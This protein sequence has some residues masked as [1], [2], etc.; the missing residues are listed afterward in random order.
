M[1]M[2]LAGTYN[3]ELYEN[4]TNLIKEVGFDFVDAAYHS[5]I[6]A[7][8]Y[9]S[10]NPE[11]MV[12]E[13]QKFINTAITNKQPFFLYFA[14]TL[15]HDPDIETALFNHS[16]AWTPKGELFGNDIPSPANT[17]MKDRKSIWAK[18]SNG[19]YKTASRIAT[20]AADIWIDDALGA[21]TNYLENQG[22]LDDTMIIVMNDHGMGAKGLLYEQGLRIIQSIRYPQLFGKPGHILPNDFIT[23]GTDLA[24]VIYDIVNI[25][26]KTQYPEYIMDG[27]S[28]INDVVNDINNPN[29]DY[30]INGP[31]SCC[32][33]R[34]GDVYNSHAVITRDYKYIFRASNVIESDGSFSSYYQNVTDIEQLYDLR[35]D[36]CEQTNIINEYNVRNITFNN[37][38]LM[39]QYLNSTACLKDNVWDCRLP[40]MTYIPPNSDFA[41]PTPAPTPIG[42]T[43]DEIVYFDKTWRGV[44][45][46]NEVS[47]AGQAKLAE[48]E[49]DLLTNNIQCGNSI[50]FI[51]YAYNFTKIGRTLTIE[52]IACCPGNMTF[53]PNWQIPDGFSPNNVLQPHIWDDIEEATSLGLREIIAINCSI[54]VLICCYIFIIIYY[55]KRRKDAE[56]AK[57]SK[58]MKANEDKER[59]KRKSGSQRPSV[60]KSIELSKDSH[61]K[62]RSS[63]IK[64]H[65]NH[66]HHHGHHY[67][68]GQ[69]RVPSGTD[70]SVSSNHRHS[71]IIP[72][73]IAM[74]MV[75][76][77]YQPSTGVTPII[78]GVTPIQGGNMN[79]NMGM[80]PITLYTKDGQPQIAYVQATPT[81]PQQYQHFQVINPNNHHQSHHSS[82]NSSRRQSFSHSHEQHQ[83]ILHSTHGHHHNHTNRFS[84]IIHQQQ[85][86]HQ[87]Y[88]AQGQTHSSTENSIH[89]KVH[90]TRPPP[91]HS[92]G[93]RSRRGSVSIS[94]FDGNVEN[95]IHSDNDNLTVTTTTTTTTHKGKDYGI[96]IKTPIEEEE[97]I[98]QYNHV[99]NGQNTIHYDP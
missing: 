91:S 89:D 12:H 31:P 71:P 52:M 69:M 6:D 58:M 5:N 40:L 9:F 46:F 81:N 99:I 29:I 76:N 83:Q 90:G 59:Q 16:A 18:A 34:F 21:L 85:H 65:P 57:I 30:D 73:A 10:H 94:S 26:L 28:W 98:F 67:E 80:T 77:N 42:M 11:W 13:S 84:G 22:I 2:A 70:G 75:P 20:A 48:A 74:A 55:L 88:Q 53:G 54:V 24:A 92:S 35:S 14:A 19:T 15:T 36:S 66:T 79:M 1:F 44:V 7:N 17:G 4:C 41:P 61:G 97:D 86:Q 8:P 23:S 78:Q 62:K 56:I 43:C 38:H 33:Y 32:E 51:E 25:D 45:I 3:L 82:V 93:A 87:P 63:I 68:H 72:P 96:D 37:Q 47:A 60:I 27:I 39:L 50:N 49:N 64:T 95:S